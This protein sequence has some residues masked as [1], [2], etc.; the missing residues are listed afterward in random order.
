MSASSNLATVYIMGLPLAL[1]ARSQEYHD[2]LARE[3]LLIGGGLD[4][5]PDQRALPRRLVQLIA[6][7]RGTYSTFAGDQDQV[8]LRARAAGQE[9]VDLSY[10][11]PVDIGDAIAALDRI[12][13]EA[14]EFC[15]QGEH[16]LTLATPPELV[17]YRRWFLSQFILQAGGGPPT[18]WPGTPTGGTG[19]E[20]AASEG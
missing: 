5:D 11:V 7:I 18:P 2:G 12:F 20:T 9:T 14:D 13:D 17:A 10:E 15:R 19:S 4:Q 3:L 16:L 8:V 1:A 6:D